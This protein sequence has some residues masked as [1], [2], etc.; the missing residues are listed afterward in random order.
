MSERGHIVWWTATRA[1][2]AINVAT[3]IALRSLGVV[4]PLW[5]WF[6]YGVALGFV[7]PVLLPLP[8]GDGFLYLGA[9]RTR[10]GRRR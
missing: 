8:R 7:C 10:T 6:L 4:A 2:L 9:P 3:T 1:T 5:V